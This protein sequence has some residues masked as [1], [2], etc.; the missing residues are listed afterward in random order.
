[1]NEDILKAK[2]IYESTI[3]LAEFVEISESDLISRICF[4]DKELF[5][6]FKKTIDYVNEFNAKPLKERVEYLG[7]SY[8]EIG[9]KTKIS[10]VL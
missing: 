7:Y 2:K 10:T 3:F 5:E 1:M 9:N 6:R 8:K 4:L